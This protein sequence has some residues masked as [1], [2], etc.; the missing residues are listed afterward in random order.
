MTRQVLVV[1]PSWVG[2]MVM[3]DALFR[4]LVQRGAAVD[5]VAPGWSLPILARMPTVRQGFE[6]GTG[7]GEFAL[8]KR[9]ALGHA[10]A[11]RNYDQAIVLPRSFKSALVPYF[12]A[13]PT[14]TGFTGEMRFG[15]INDRR[16]FDRALLDQTVKRFVYLGLAP[17]ESLPAELPRPALVPLPEAVHT[18]CERLEL[19]PT[20]PTVALLPGAEYGPAKCW[21]ISYYRTLAEKLHERGATVWVL[22][23]E[24]DRPAG[25]VISAGGV[26]TNLAGRT[27]LAEAADLLGCCTVA[28]S[29]DSGL[30]HVAAAVGCWVVAI[31]GSSSP[32]FTPPLTDRASVLYRALPCSP[33]FERECPLQHLDCLTGIR[34]DDVL[35]RI[36][37][38]L[39]PSA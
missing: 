32:D 20:P 33:C 13:I 34:P 19:R 30:M 38:R 37:P 11:D 16:P 18:T 7:H 14:R 35:E 25:E 9:R 15:L 17:G 22:G 26:A 29:N 3:A 5:V 31:Y 24:K 1:G 21:P 6:L 23:S 12:A 10:L 27:T 36:Q 39:A 28:V 4:L 8:G 2:D